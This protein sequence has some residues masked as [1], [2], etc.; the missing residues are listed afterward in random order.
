MIMKK[1]SNES[2]TYGNKK[3]KQTGAAEGEINHYS[4]IHAVGGKQRN[5]QHYDGHSESL[6][7]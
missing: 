1:E 7:D 2:S 6:S 5:K 3:I 4:R